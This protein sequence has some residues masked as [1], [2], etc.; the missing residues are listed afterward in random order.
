MEI[1]AIDDFMAFGRRI[2]PG[3][4]IDLPVADAHYIIGLGRAEA[5]GSDEPAAKKKPAPKRKAKD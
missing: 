1:R 4:V 3:E 2:E 5:I